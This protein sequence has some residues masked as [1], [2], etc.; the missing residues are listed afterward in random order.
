MFQ[1]ECVCWCWCQSRVDI[2]STTEEQLFDED[3]LTT[4]LC[5]DVLD[6]SFGFEAWLSP[7][8][9][10]KAYLN[11]LA[12]GGEGFVGTRCC[13]YCF[14]VLIRIYIFKCLFF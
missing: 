13:R 8:Q 5:G 3:E 9:G 11:E 12:T 2:L 1:D 6:G 14:C 10:G 4:V 7:M